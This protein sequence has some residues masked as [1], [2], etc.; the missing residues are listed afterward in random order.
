MRC[1]S[2]ARRARARPAWPVP[3]PT[4]LK[5]GSGR[6]PFRRRWPTSRRRTIG[7]VRRWPTTASRGYSAR[8]PRGVPVVVF[9]RFGRPVI[10]QHRAAQNVQRRARLP[11]ETAH[12][13]PRFATV[14]HD[15]GFA[16]AFHVA[17]VFECARLELRFGHF[18]THIGPLMSMVMEPLSWWV[19]IGRQT[20]RHALSA[21]SLSTLQS[22]EPR[23]TAPPARPAA[24]PV[25]TVWRLA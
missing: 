13:Q 9:H 12:F 23:R 14:G 8:S 17:Q 4:C 24:C 21:Q 25:T 5:R 7:R 11:S 22:D 19:R 20:R 18:G 3:R 2:T 10:T 6:R 16:A 1:P 15:E